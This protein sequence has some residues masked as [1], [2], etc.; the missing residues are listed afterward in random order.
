MALL[1]GG[2]WI[3]DSELIVILDTPDPSITYFCRTKAGNWTTA[4]K[5]LAQWQIWI[6]DADGNKLFAQG[7][8]RFKHVYNDRAGYTY[9]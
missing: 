7:I 9:K 8:S 4:G 6:N 2:E 1:N 5:A 3:D